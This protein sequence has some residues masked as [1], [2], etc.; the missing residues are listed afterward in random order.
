MSKL[1]VPRY[2]YA[3]L[4]RKVGLRV[5]L[6]W[7]H[8][9]GR[10]N[11]R[12]TR[13]FSRMLKE[14]DFTQQG[15]IPRVILIEVT[16]AVG[17]SFDINSTVETKGSADRITWA[18]LVGGVVGGA[19]AALTGREDLKE[20]FEV[21]KVTPFMIPRLRAVVET[22]AHAIIPYKVGDSFTAEGEF[23]SLLDCLN[24]IREKI[25]G[26]DTTSEEPSVAGREIQLK[27]RN[28]ETGVLTD[29]G[30]VLTDADGNF[31]I[32]SPPLTEEGI[33][34]GFIRHPEDDVYEAH[35]SRN[36]FTFRVKKV[37]TAIL[38]MTIS[39]LELIYA[40]L[41]RITIEGKLRG[42]KLDIEN[43]E[44]ITDLNLETGLSGKPIKIYIYPNSDVG[45][46]VLLTIVPSGAD[47]SFTF[48]TTIT[49]CLRALGISIPTKPQEVVYFGVL[50][51]FEGDNHYRECDNKTLVPK[52]VAGM[53]TVLTAERT[54]TDIKI[55]YRVDDT[56]SLKG[57][58][59]DIDLTGFPRRV[60][61]P[62]TGVDVEILDLGFKAV[63]DSDGKYEGKIVLTQTTEDS[64]R[65]YAEYVTE[66]IHPTTGKR[67]ISRAMPLFVMRH[68]VKITCAP[69]KIIAVSNTGVVGKDITLTGHV[70]RETLDW[71]EVATGEFTFAIPNHPVALYEILAPDT[72]S[73]TAF[74]KEIMPIFGLPAPGGV[75]TW[76]LLAKGV[77]ESDGSYSLTFTPDK[78]S[79]GMKCW[80]V[81]PKTPKYRHD[82]TAISIRIIKAGTL[83]KNL[84][85]D[86]TRTDVGKKVSITGRLMADPP[87]LPEIP[88]ANA[89]V[90]ITGSKFLGTRLTSSGTPID[91]GTL[92]TDANG[93]FT[94][95]YTPTSAMILSLYAV[96]DGVDGK[97]NSTDTKAT[98]LRLTVSTSGTVRGTKHC[99][100][101]DADFATDAELDRHISE[102]HQGEEK[103][104]C[105]WKPY[106]LGSIVRYLW[107]RAKGML[108]R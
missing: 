71:R 52:A 79:K 16:P 33:Y 23:T 69:F 60:E 46:K 65:G 73:E 19:L 21:R 76:R 54:L 67:I 104:P 8:D 105:D 95:G 90:K 9:Q 4:R 44:H 81:S 12:F 20:T 42:A 30:S 5:T 55:V 61:Y 85:L 102:A 2:W 43:K 11:L 63:T 48:G 91:I 89:T 83:F 84:R 51:E 64:P 87:D 41:E 24:K 59:M 68:P 13:P 27:A 7:Y 1:L 25:E 62:H 39:P 37:L 96:F 101:S 75:T 100:Y 94:F 26:E 53:L 97:Y 70:Y 77:T 78:E 40:P 31:A 74:L 14:T 106:K 99:P 47:G 56:L 49:D 86:R 108:G 58:F 107:C 50:T 10:Y 57:A 3:N 103:P 29:F 34:R 66:A 35:D 36:Y 32:T 92:Q 22:L 15:E 18:A 17:G 93:N 88:L 98:L 45:R 6:P 82:K 80:V 72:M 28:V 38:P